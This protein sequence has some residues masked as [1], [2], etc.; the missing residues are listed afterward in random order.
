M[1]SKSGRAGG[2]AAPAPPSAARSRTAKPAARRMPRARVSDS[3]DSDHADH[4]AIE[5]DED[6]EDRM[7]IDA[8]SDD[9]NGSSEAPSDSDAEDDDD[10]EGPSFA[11][12]AEQRER[13]GKKAF[14]E[15]MQ[16]QRDKAAG[17][18]G[19]SK[20]S[21]KNAPMEMSSKRAVSRKRQ[22]VDVA[23]PKRRDPRFDNLSGKLNEDLFKK[24]YSFIDEYKER[25]LVELKQ[26]L[27]KTK[28]RDESTRLIQ[29]IQ[30]I[31]NRRR[32]ERERELQQKI[33]RE[34]RKSEVEK[35]KQGKKPF[36][37]KKSEERRLQLI[38]K[39][40]A[41]SDKELEKMA[42]KKRKR[43]AG[44]DRKFMPR[45]RAGAGGD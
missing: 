12:L 39:L 41:K 45:R 26:T 20:R 21:N 17:K 18:S 14:T 4:H 19:K 3:E 40:K 28:D 37:L 24:S 44:K 34:W 5:S 43:D 31:E 27:A 9:E 33:K 42:E 11:E 22:V 35:I 32:A 6:D 7:S 36:F 16:G 15:M 29:T 2:R 23:A 25:E 1:S 13:M 38:S 8:D 30:A 10:A